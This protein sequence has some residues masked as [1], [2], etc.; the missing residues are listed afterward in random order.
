IEPSQTFVVQSSR[1]PSNQPRTYSPSSTLGT[2]R[3]RPR[4]RSAFTSGGAKCHGC[5]EA[6][7]SAADLDRSA[8]CTSRVL[9][10]DL[11]LHLVPRLRTL[12]RSSSRCEL[13]PYVSAAILLKRAHG[14]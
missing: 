11:G 3:F 1:A 8:H 9:R 2:K 4:R 6:R 7:A 13:P 5:A 10:P 12:S 14:R